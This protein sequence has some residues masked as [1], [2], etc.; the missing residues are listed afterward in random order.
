MREAG[1]T[2]WNTGMRQGVTTECKQ[3]ELDKK[4]QDGSEAKTEVVVLLCT[5]HSVMK[6]GEGKAG[7]TTPISKGLQRLAREEKSA[8]QSSA[9]GQ[10][11]LRPS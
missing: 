2:H 3:G 5:R 1:L 4:A 10:V 7:R 8:C 11:R 9:R 6:H